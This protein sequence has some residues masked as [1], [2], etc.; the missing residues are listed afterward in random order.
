MFP[1]SAPL[2]SHVQVAGTAIELCGTGNGTQGPIYDPVSKILVNLVMPPVIRR[3]G[4]GRILSMGTVTWVLRYILF[5]LGAS[6]AVLGMTCGGVTLKG[7]CY[8]GL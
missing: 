1:R 8:R 5:A 4:V 3:M 2:L 7:I 6:D